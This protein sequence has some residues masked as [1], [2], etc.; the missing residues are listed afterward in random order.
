MKKLD[1]QEVLNYAPGTAVYFGA[2]VAI[3]SRHGGFL[4]FNN[5]S[6][7]RAS[8][9]KILPSA[10]FTIWNCDDLQDHGVVRYGDAVWLQV[11]LYSTAL[12]FILL[13]RSA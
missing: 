6:D 9:H 7:I 2:T 10:R 3:Q 13:G 5:A 4:S 11:L 8:A 1:L 12:I